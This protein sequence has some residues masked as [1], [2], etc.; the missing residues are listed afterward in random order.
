MRISVFFLLCAAAQCTNAVEIA[1]TPS[2]TEIEPHH[3]TIL[4]ADDAEGSE[5]LPRF[6]GSTGPKRLWITGFE[7]SSQ[8]LSWDISVTESGFYDISLISEGIPTMRLKVGGTFF[9]ELILKESDF[10]K[11]NKNSF[12]V[13]PLLKGKTKIQIQLSNDIVDPNKARLRGVELFPLSAKDNYEKR[14]T[15]LRADTSWMSQKGYGVMLQ[16]GAWGFPE[17][18]PKTPWEEVV[19]TFDVE[20]FAK[21]VDEDMGA[22]WVIWSITWRSSY[23]P[24]PLESVDALVPGHTT[25]RDLPMDLANALQKRGIR[26]MFYYHPGYEDKNF[27]ATNHWKNNRQKGDFFKHWTAIVSEIGARYGDKLSGWFF[28]DGCVYSPTPSEFPFEK[29]TVAAKTGFNNRVVSY[30]NWVLPAITDFQDVQMGE[31]FRGDT[32]TTLSGEGIYSD[33][34]LKGMHAHGMI[35]VNADDWGVWKP[36]SKIKLIVSASDAIKIARNANAH[37]QAITF[38]FNMYEDAVV[39]TETLAM[40]RQLRSAIYDKP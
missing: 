21:M 30:N 7:K 23:F 17:H 39:T 19:K 12:G 38:N 36:D 8:S 11:F 10:S 37:G 5:G 15:D 26:L 35:C 33:G 27:W 28:D 29:L 40:F 1:P 34:P 32:N 31:G 2:M 13:V 20:K 6:A 4:M 18:G 3:K 25:S 24:M 14:V 16:Y 22:R 9:S